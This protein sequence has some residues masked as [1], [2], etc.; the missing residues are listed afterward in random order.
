MDFRDMSN[1]LNESR[2]ES[3]LFSEFHPTA[4]PKVTYQVP[5]ECISKEM[6]DSLSVYI[7]PKLELQG[8]LMTVN[9]LGYKIIG[10]P[11]GID[12]RKYAR[13]RL[14]FNL[15]FVCK[16]KS[17]TVQ[18]EPLVRKLSNY[19]ISLELESGFLSNEETK[20]LLPDIMTK[21]C[22]ELNKNGRC[23]IPIN[24]SNTIHLKVIPVHHDPE[25]VNDH[26][27]PVFV[28]SHT[29][30][31][32]HHWDLTT[33]QILPYVDGFRHVARIAA[34]A[35]VE[36][37][38]V[39]ACIQNM[40]YYRV[41]TIIPIFQ[42]SNVYTCTPEM[43]S[44]ARDTKLQEDCLKFVA[45]Q[46]R[47]APTFRS[48]FMLYCGLTY[49]TSVRD[50]CTR[51]NPHMLGV[52]ERKLVQFGLMKGLIRRIHKYPVQL[53]PDINSLSRQKGLAKYFNGEHHFDEICCK[54]GMSYQELEDIVEQD[55]NVV[56]CCK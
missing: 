18:Y 7:I 24:T 37:S 17:R 36:V 16:S 12:D 11:V 52:D 1:R 21:I 47:P 32:P 50:I 25:E 33:Q 40:V 38:L 20:S 56:V 14:I 3:L 4:G 31:L 10:Y 19:L 43:S 5:A 2:I 13:N 9:A 34:E 53:S 46:G 29:S 45:K 54:T 48:V 30:L 28:E 6:F 44:L 41:V 8:N 23:S 51:S 22:L 49:G 55:R 39:K 35:D 27:V 26:D 42:Y 15:C